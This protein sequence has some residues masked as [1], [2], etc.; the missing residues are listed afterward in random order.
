M[1]IILAFC[2]FAFFACGDSGSASNTSQDNTSSN[3]GGDYKT[4]I[5]DKLNVYIDKMTKGDYD[6]MLDLTYPKLFD[7]APREMMLGVL[8]QT[9]GAEGMNISFS[10][11][12]IL[13]VHDKVVEDGGNKYTLVDYRMKMNMGLEGEMAEVAEMMIPTFNQQFGEDNVDFNVET[14]TFTINMNSQMVA[15]QEKGKWYFLENREEQK[16]ILKTVIGEEVLSKLGV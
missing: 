14:T 3:N 1:R 16:S 12:E 7:I 2:L 15:I 9:F 13:K 5:Q 6:A 8:K 10:D 4:E 11:S